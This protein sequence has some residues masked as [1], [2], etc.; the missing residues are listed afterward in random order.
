MYG[1]L[2]D[3][4]PSSPAHIVPRSWKRLWKSGEKMCNALKNNK[5]IHGVLNCMDIVVCFSYFRLSFNNMF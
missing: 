3:R 4:L 5:V 1:G 2:I